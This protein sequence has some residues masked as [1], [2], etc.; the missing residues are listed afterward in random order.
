M[1][2]P[3]SIFKGHVI[4]LKRLLDK[5]FQHTTLG[6]S[7]KGW[8]KYPDT[9]KEGAPHNIEWEYGILHHDSVTHMFLE[10]ILIMKNEADYR[11]YSINIGETQ[12][13]AEEKGFYFSE[14]KY[15]TLERVKQDLKTNK[16]KLYNSL[17]GNNNEL[18]NFNPYT[19]RVADFNWIYEI[20]SLYLK[21]EQ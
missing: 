14:N 12:E 15:P 7:E 3:Q 21:E 9:I 10:N 11:L 17:I 2:I 19:E 4:D 6:D 13:S 8:T 18:C 16:F 5:L 20:I 1:K